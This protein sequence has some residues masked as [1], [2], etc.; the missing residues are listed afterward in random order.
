MTPRTAKKH[1]F[2]L[3]IKSKDGRVVLSYDPLSKKWIARSGDKVLARRRNI[4]VLVDAVNGAE[5]A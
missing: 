3:A 5:G 4:A 1:T 2:D